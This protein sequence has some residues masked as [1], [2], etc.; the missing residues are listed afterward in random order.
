MNK[1][2]YIT[3]SSEAF[4]FEIESQILAPSLPKHEEE[5]PQWSGQGGWSSDNWTGTDADE[6]E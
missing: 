6:A 1:K 4:N 3:P 2:K 5:K